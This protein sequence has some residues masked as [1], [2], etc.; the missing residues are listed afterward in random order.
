SSTCVSSGTT[1]SRTN[2]RTAARMSSSSVL[3]MVPLLRDGGLQLI[4]AT[5]RRSGSGAA[6][7][8]G[9]HHGPFSNCFVAHP[10]LALSGSQLKVIIPL[11]SRISEL[12]G[13]GPPCSQPC[14]PRLEVQ[15]SRSCGFSLE[16]QGSRTC[17]LR[18]DTPG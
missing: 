8:Q 14:V 4:R 7:R 16:V 6:V 2:S 18:L 15:G 10:T 1:F 13:T 11:R 9:G 12:G 3:S 5:G 17:R